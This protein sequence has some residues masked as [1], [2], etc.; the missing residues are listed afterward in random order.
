MA[1][2][3][4]LLLARVIEPFATYYVPTTDE[5]NRNHFTV[6]YFAACRFE[7]TGTE[8]QKRKNES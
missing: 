1:S 8:H 2:A 5:S 7:Y 4:N 3:I 6:S